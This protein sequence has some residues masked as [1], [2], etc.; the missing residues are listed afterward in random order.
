[1]SW[2]QVQKKL[3]N[4]TAV[5]SGVSYDSDVT[6]GNLLI[7]IAG[8]NVTGQTTLPTVSGFAKAKERLGTNCG[9]GIWW[10]R[11]DTSGARSVTASGFLGSYS[12]AIAEY[13]FTEA[14]NPVVAGTPT[15]NA[16]T[17][18]TSINGL[19][20]APAGDKLIVSAARLSG[21][22]STPR[23]WSDSF[24]EQNDTNARGSWSHILTTATGFGPSYTWVGS[25]NA[26]LVMCA[27][28]VSATSVSSLVKV[29]ASNTFT[30]R[31]VKVRLSNAWVTV[32]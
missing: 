24:V 29:R 26:A 25:L 7:A 1:V 12:L 9:I 19:L 30:A 6:A 31:P 5:G 32:T 4:G 8:M 15:D 21:G 20:S 3:V 13:S 10:T 14:G 22:S 11:A 17:A 23:S 28:S 27:F 16:V 18:T 2:T